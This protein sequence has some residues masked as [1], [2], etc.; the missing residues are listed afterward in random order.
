M[1]L[2]SVAARETAAPVPGQQLGQASVN[3]K[4]FEV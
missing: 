3:V 4:E 2:L 1:L